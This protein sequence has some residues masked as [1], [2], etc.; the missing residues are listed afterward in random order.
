MGR[1]DCLI[2]YFTEMIK[3]GRLDWKH[4]RHFNADSET[5]RIYQA[6]RG[7]RDVSGDWIDYY[8]YNEVATTVDPIYDEAVGQGRIYFPRVRVPVLHVVLQYGDNENTDI[9]F[10]FNNTLEIVCAFDQFVG[11]GMQ[12]ADV[13]AGNYLKDRLYYKQEVFRV[14]QVVPKGQIQQRPTLITISATQLKPDELVDDQ[15]FSQWAGSSGPN[16]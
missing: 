5:D 2:Y 13:K 15:L 9:G 3:I 8:H 10:Y 11:V 14:T 16:L 4:G 1:L 7:W 6:M 12:Y